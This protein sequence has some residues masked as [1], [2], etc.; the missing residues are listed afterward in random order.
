M[1]RAWDA[2]S[3]QDTGTSIPLSEQGFVSA[4]VSSWSQAFCG[5][6]P[7][8]LVGGNETKSRL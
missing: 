7:A 2:G 1:G 4:V 6:G 3:S 8:D 5:Q